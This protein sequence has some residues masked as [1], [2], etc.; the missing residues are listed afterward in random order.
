MLNIL[1]L[2]VGLVTSLALGASAQSVEY[3]ELPADFQANA[4][5]TIGSVV[6]ILLAIRVMP[7]AW[8]YLVQFFGKKNA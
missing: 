8:K 4:L 7:V 6:T 3:F 2:A 1:S 5:L